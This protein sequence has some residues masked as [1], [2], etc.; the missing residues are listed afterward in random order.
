[1]EEIR[2]GLWTWTG[3]HS[4]WT[5]ELAWEPEA[6]SY[7]VDIGSLCVLIDPV[8]PVPRADAILLTVPWHRRDTDELELPVLEI[9]PAGIEAVPSFFAEETAFW[10]PAHKAIVLGDGIAD[11]HTAPIEWE[12]DDPEAS[13]RLRALLELPFDLVLPTHG[14]IT[15]RAGFEASLDVD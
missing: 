1:M 14:E 10:L 4:E 15:D 7:A 9:P 13:T 6:R 3:E 12:T 8:L 5:R 2:P 11:G